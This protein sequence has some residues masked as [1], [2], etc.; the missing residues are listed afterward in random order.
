MT[1]K[2]QSASPP[3]ESRN[4]RVIIVDDHEVVRRGLADLIDREPGLEVCGECGTA[5]EVLPAVRSQ[6]P[7][8]AV[9]D[10]TLGAESGLDVI[11]EIATSNPDVRVLVLS[12]HDELLFAERA[13]RAGALGYVMKTRPAADLLRAVRRVAAG[14]TSVSEQVAERIMATL[15]GRETR[16]GASAIDRLSD[17]ERQVFML[18]GEGLVTREIAER[19]SISV[20]TVESHYEHIK[21]KLGLTSGRDMLRLALTWTQEHPH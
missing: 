1:P 11:R 5:A 7:D 18:V 14:R 13:L 3:A 16:V 21:D 20:K 10:L 9:V 2:S 15:G 12:A 6:H 8:V 17:R 4:V 19:L